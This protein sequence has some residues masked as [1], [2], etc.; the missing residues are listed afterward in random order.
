MAKKSMESD[1]T[2]EKAT[3]IIEAAAE[4]AVD[5]TAFGVLSAI[6]HNGKQYN[7]GETISLLLHEAAA[8]AESNAIEALK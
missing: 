4:S 1:V 7:A 5:K 8:L 6:V 3:E 2:I